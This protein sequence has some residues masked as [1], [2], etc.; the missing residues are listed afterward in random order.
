MVVHWEV[1]TDI[2]VFNSGVVLA[3]SMQFDGQF[4]T[5][6]SSQVYKAAQSH[7]RSLDIRFLPVDYL[8]KHW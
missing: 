6:V 8:T 1:G 2:P 4:S 3:D 5:S 7:K